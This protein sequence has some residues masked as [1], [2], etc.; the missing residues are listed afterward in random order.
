MQHEN[1]SR[2]P[3]EPNTTPP[4]KQLQDT[5]A[6]TTPTEWLP[7]AWE[8]RDR[9]KARMRDLAEALRG[10]MGPA[11]G[12]VIPALSSRLAGLSD[13]QVLELLLYLDELVEYLYYGERGRE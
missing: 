4:Q 10:V 5:L 3:S 8:V 6:T 12:L 1:E 13:K 7:E 9:I 11:S 2:P